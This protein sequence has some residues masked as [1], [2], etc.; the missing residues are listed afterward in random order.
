MKWFKHDSNA[1]FDAKL[2]KVRLRYGMQGYGLYWYCLEQIAKNVDQHNLTFELEEDAELIAADTGIHYEQVNEMMLYFVTLKL[3]ENN[4][5]IITCIK[6][7]RRTDEYTQQ[8]IRSQEVLGSQSRES[9]D[10]LPGIR[11]EQNRTEYISKK[12]RTNKNSDINKKI[13]KTFKPP[14]I[15]EI[16]SYCNERKNSVDPEKFFYFYESKQW[17]IGKNKMKNWKA[18]VIT[19]EKNSTNNHS[20]MSEVIN[21]I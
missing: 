16:K 19:W 20:V 11:I 8:L 9:T 18:A 12:K 15:E 2:K 13:S 5:G 21:A 3:F 6:M 14:S 10:K 7:L 17:F 1:S 4:N